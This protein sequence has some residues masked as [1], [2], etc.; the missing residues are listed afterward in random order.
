MK[1]VL[2]FCAL[3]IPA[4]GFANGI[5]IPFD[6]SIE[7]EK[8]NKTYVQHDYGSGVRW[9]KDYIVTAKHVSFVEGSIY[10]CSENC[11]L[12]FIKKSDNSK[13]IPEWREPITSENVVISG[14]HGYG[15]LIDSKGKT[16]HQDFFVNQGKVLN[17]LENERQKNS[18]VYATTAKVY[19]GQSGG[20][21]TGEDNKVIGILIGETQ[22]S[23]NKNR[24]FK[25][26][27]FIP[28]HVIKQ[29]WIVF[30]KI[31]KNEEY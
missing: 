17:Y 7:F 12:Q 21:V 9:N 26:S 27:I 25:V 29:E 3:T 28:Y 22:V 30:N 5:A 24:N 10:Q 4:M 11:D 18:L 20:P 2:L 15:R 14:N 8:N 19:P 6:R 16:F 13:N 31:S 1:N 23:D